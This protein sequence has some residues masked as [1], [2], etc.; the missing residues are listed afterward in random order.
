MH[1]LT[2]LPSDMPMRSYSIEYDEKGNRIEKREYDSNGSLKF[3]FRTQHDEKENRIKEYKHKP[4][5][6]LF[7][8]LTFK[9]DKEGNIIEQQNYYYFPPEK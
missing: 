7:D 1:Y 4:N 2:E 3:R 8:S 6:E 5:G 9:H